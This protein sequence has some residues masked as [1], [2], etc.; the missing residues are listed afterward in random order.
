MCKNRD[1]HGNIYTVQIALIGKNIFNKNL[2]DLLSAFFL[3]VT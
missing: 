3:F 2:M 1:S